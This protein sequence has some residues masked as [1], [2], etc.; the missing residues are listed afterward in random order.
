[1]RNVILDTTK[2]FQKSFLQTIF[3]IFS[4]FIIILCISFNWIF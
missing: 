1:M 4:F 3:L 2:I